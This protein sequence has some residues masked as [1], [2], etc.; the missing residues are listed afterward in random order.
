MM[1]LERAEDEMNILQ[2][3]AGLMFNQDY[4]ASLPRSQTQ[5]KISIP[6]NFFF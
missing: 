5:M 6:L 1:W 2:E 4:E 3:E